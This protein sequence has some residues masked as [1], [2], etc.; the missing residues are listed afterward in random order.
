M[1]DS[2]LLGGVQASACY[3]TIF[4][5]VVVISF[6]IGAS[7]APLLELMAEV[8]FPSSEGITANAVIMGQQIATLLIPGLVPTL[9]ETTAFAVCN[10]ILAVA[11][12]VCFALTLPVQQRY[13][14]RLGRHGGQAQRP[15]SA[16]AM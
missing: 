15:R 12:A 10:C 11:A 6:T 1:G 5:L 9:P 14:R 8:A 13:R 3:W 7:M 4:V 2:L 16:P